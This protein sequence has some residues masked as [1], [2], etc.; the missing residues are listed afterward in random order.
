VV[1][2]AALLEAVWSDAVVTEGVLKT[3]LGQIRQ[4][5]GARAK[6]PRYIATVHR[7]GYRFIA[8]VT[9]VERLLAAD[10]TLAQRPVAFARQLQGSEPGCGA[11][12]LIVGREAELTQLH[13]WWARAL[14]GERQ[15]VVVTGEAGIGKTTLVDTF[16]AQVVGTEP[17]WIGRG[18]CI[19]HYGAGEAYLPLLEAL[20]RLCRG[21][22]GNRLFDLLHHHAPSGLMQLPGFVSTTALEGLQRRVRR[23]PNSLPPP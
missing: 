13:Q 21:P 20:G 23:E 9:V 8:P 11:S 18:Q 17:L 22:D 15:V 7:Q 5:L 6:T 4:A 3:C 16:A 14:K 1:T 2:K 12:R 19:E 10:I